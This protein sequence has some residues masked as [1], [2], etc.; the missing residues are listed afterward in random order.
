MKKIT[1]LLFSVLI[2]LNSSFACSY[3]PISFC[4]TSEEKD[5]DIIVSG[6]I[7][8]IDSDGI[9]LQVLEVLRGEENRSILRIWDGTDFDCNGL[10]SMASSDLGSVNDS[11][12]VILPKIDSLQNTWDVIGDYRRPNYF[13]YIPKLIIKDGIVE[14][15]IKGLTGAPT[16][17][18]ANSVNYDEFIETYTSNGDC[19]EIKVGTNDINGLNQS[20]IFNNPVNNSLKIKITNQSSNQKTINIYNSYGI[21]V[22]SIKSR[23]EDIGINTS[24]FPAGI[25]F[26]KVSYENKKTTIFKFTKI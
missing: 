8:S 4:A 13:G 7:I 20:I 25:Y 24:Q 1:L 22:K 6:K 19:S 2:Y 26:G 11:I 14:G 23:N 16:E 3:Y 21:F 15:F 10:F 5:E 17:Y 18:I 9:N 12:I